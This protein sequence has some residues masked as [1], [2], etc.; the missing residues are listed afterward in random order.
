[1]RELAFGD[2]TR[3]GLACYGRN[4]TYHCGLRGDGSPLRLETPRFAAPLLRVELDGRRV[5]P[6]AFAPFSID[7]GTPSA[8]EH[9]LDLTAYGNRVNTF[10]QLH[11]ADDEIFWTGPGSWRSKGA[12]WA[13]EYQ[14]R[15]AGVLVAPIVWEGAG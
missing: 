9:R 11:H 3:Q 15:R 5:G 10:G 7:L 14:L 2:W 13:Y 1:M 8:G 6:I 4:V 12:K